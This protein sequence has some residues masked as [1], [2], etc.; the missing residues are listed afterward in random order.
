MLALTNLY[1]NPLQPG[2]APFNRQLFRALA[3]TVA[4]HIIA[5]IAWTDE[6]RCRRSSDAS[7][8]DRRTSHDGIT[9][10]YPRFLFPPKVLRSWYGHCLL[11]SVRAAFDRAMQEFRPDVIYGSWAYPDGWAAVELGH[12]AGLPVVVRVHGSDIHLLN[13]FPGR[14][15]RTVETLKRADRVIAPSRELADRVVELGAEPRRV[16][17]IYNGVDAAL[18]HPSPRELSRRQ[19]NLPAGKPMILFAGNLVPLKGIDLLIDACARLAAEKVDFICHLV[20]QGPMRSQLERRVQSKGLG[21]RVVFQGPKSIEELPDWYRSADV[22]ALP[23]WSEGVP[24]VL[25]EAMACGTQFVA[26]RVGGIPEIAHL[27]RGTLVPAGD[28][29]GLTSAIR[30]SLVAAHSDDALA[31]SPPR[32]FGDTATELIRILQEV[33]GR[34]NSEDADLAG[35]ADKVEVQSR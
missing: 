30:E 2:R 3:K 6:V 21:E 7:L 31:T 25:L 19:L 13:Q 8:G 33:I 34:R 4:L 20:G 11:R 26:S 24:N 29:A 27:G 35:H 1:P 32:T 23:S 18:F 9:V 10:D 22:F 17:I 15:G 12:R 16:H 5:P 28:V 14:R